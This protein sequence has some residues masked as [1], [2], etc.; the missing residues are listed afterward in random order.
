MLQHY[1][2]ARELTGERLHKQQMNIS[3]LSLDAKKQKKKRKT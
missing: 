3:T 1:F 2:I